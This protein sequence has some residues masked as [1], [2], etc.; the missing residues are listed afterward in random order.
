MLASDDLVS[1]MARTV[2]G[3][4]QK[5]RFQ[6][7]ADE[8]RIVGVGRSIS[9][10][11]LTLWVRRSWKPEFFVFMPRADGRNSHVSYHRNGTYHYKTDGRIVG[12]PKKLQ[13]LDQPFKGTEHLGGFKGHGPK[14]VGAVC[15]PSV[16]TGVVELPP[17]LLGPRD[18][19]VLVDL[20][21]PGCDPITLSGDM[22]RQK[23]F[24]DAVPWLVIRIFG[25]PAPDS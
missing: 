5:A 17:G 25:T 4:Q 7:R 11:W 1:E 2:R 9:G 12:T 6:G 13:R 15:D 23:T 16:F 24:D 21:E 19:V 20:V 22:I 3:D 18:G 8:A 10:L 14:S